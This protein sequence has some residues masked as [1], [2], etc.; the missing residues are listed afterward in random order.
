[1]SRWSLPACLCLAILAVSCG[2]PP[3][4]EMDQAQGALDAARAAGADRYAATEFAAAA[5]ALARSRQAVKDRDY[6]LAL[7]D[8]L[9]S[10]ERAQNAARDA[11]ETKARLR[12]DLERLIIEVNGLVARA[13]QGSVAAER[14][15]TPR[16]ALRIH[17][18]AVAVATAEVQK[19]GA[20]VADGD[21]AAV[22]TTLAGTKQR[23]TMTIAA[24]DGLAT[25]QTPRRRR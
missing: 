11:A 2:E 5:D 7:N 16:A 18:E 25:P 20:A 1:M 9:D 17:Q 6:R 10:R 24:L 3:N 19:A 21:Y 4:K 8:A 15:R 22:T 12:A 13:A 14:A 23:L